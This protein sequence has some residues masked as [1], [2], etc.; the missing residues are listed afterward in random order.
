MASD[1]FDLS[2][3][4]GA[5]NDTS[6]QLSLLIDGKL[7]IGTD[8]LTANE[9]IAPNSGDPRAI[10]SPYM[11]VQHAMFQ[12]SH[13]Q[14]AT[15]LKELNPNWTDAK[16]YDTAR[17]INRAIFQKVTYEEWLPSVVGARL[18]A[19]IRNNNEELIRDPAVRG[20]SNEFATAAIRFYNSM[21]PGDLYETSSGGGNGSNNIQK[22]LFEL[23]D[24]FYHPRALNWTRD[25]T[26]KIVSSTLTQK[27][28]AL[29]TSYVDDVSRVNY[30]A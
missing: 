4:Y 5:T 20:V 15:Q 14:I 29:D 23:R 21:L 3:V 25:T 22:K 8:A 10:Y 26:A 2:Q 24:T 30:F 6:S 27:A 17:R 12:R 7:R 19:R 1:I 13:N 11:I 18:G 28:M 9:P 16:L